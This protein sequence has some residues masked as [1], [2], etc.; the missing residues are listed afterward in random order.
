[1]VNSVGLQGPGIEAWLHDDLPRLAAAG[2]RTVVSIWG[3]RVDDR[4][5]RRPPRVGRGPDRRRGERELSQRRGPT[6]HVRPLARGDRRGVVGCL[7]HPYPGL[8]CWAKLSPT[9]SDLAE[10]AGAALDGGAEGITLIDTALA[11]VIDVERRTPMLGSGPAG[12]GLSG[13]S[14]HP[15]AVMSTSG[16]PIPTP[17]SSAWAE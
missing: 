13:P 3:Q 16:P 10:I 6:P 15:I 4:G 2:A 11:M 8:P 5:C 7:D 14:V 12:G 17:P 9:V 1:M